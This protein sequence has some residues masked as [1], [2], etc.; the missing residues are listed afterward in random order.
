MKDENGRRN[1][2]E[3]GG[4]PRTTLRP[5]VTRA[6]RHEIRQERARLLDKRLQRYTEEIE[7][8]HRTWDD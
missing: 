4:R 8:W 1:V 3:Q 6:K 7:S 5:C 2:T